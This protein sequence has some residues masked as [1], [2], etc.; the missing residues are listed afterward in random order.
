MIHDVLP[1]QVGL[2][3]ECRW[4]KIEIPAPLRRWCDLRKV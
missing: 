4:R 2:E 1:A 3:M